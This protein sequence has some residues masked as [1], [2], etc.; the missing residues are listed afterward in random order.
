MGNI[1]FNLLFDFTWIFLAICDPHEP[2]M[3]DTNKELPHTMFATRQI[4]ISGAAVGQTQSQKL[5]K[6]D[7]YKMDPR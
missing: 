1:D 7:K 5:R 4:F 2:N 3:T 6:Q